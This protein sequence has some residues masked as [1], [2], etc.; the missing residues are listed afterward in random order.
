MLN[1][2]TKT[3]MGKV[4]ETNQDSC[5]W[6][7]LGENALWAVVCDGMGGANGGNVASAM[8]IEIISE[9]LAQDFT[10]DMDGEE[11]RDLMD[12]AIMAANSGVYELAN[13]DSELY[14]M[15]TTVVMV[16]IVDDTV[17]IAHVGDSRIY[18]IY[19]DEIKQLSNDHSMV[20]MLVDLGEITAEEAKHHPKKNI[21]TRAVGVD[22]TVDIDFCELTLRKGEKLLLCSDGLTNF[23][24]DEDLRNIIEENDGQEAVELLIENANNNGGGDNITAVLICGDAKESDNAVNEE[25]ETEAEEV[26]EE[27]N[28]ED[29]ENSEDDSEEIAETS[30]DSS[31]DEDE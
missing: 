21:I 8:A 14:G 27:K 5:S 30:E 9:K 1:V 23:V 16:V 3:D 20:Q 6:S 13:E 12:A 7:R 2:Y 18:S 11:V 22:D 4:R 31:E 29:C 26:E 24:E 10:S 19:N 17:Q 28:E 25:V 15:G